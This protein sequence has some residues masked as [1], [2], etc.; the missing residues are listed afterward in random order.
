[1]MILLEKKDVNT[2]TSNERV[3]GLHTALLEI[4]KNNIQG[5]IIECGIFMG[6]NII[7][8]KTFFDSVND[9]RKYHCFDTFTGM[10]EPSQEDG[11]VAKEKWNK[12]SNSWCKASLEKVKDEFAK[13]NKLDNSVSF[14]VGDVANTLLQEHNIP[15]RIALLRLDTDWYESTLIELKILYPKLVSGGYLIIDDYG[16]WDGAKKAVDEYFGEDFVSIYFT[17]L[18]Y[19]GIMI[20][21]A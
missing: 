9:K 16:H 7:I 19:T 11:I 4:H 17:K 18:D 6:G 2:R 12:K 1:M 20:K 10:I 13:H 5:D 14:I 21:K 3:K 8:A 15:E